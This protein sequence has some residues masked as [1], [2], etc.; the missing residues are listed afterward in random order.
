MLGT[1]LLVFGCHFSRHRPG[2]LTACRYLPFLRLT[3]L[4]PL[5]PLPL[6]LVALLRI[7]LLTLS[8]SSSLVILSNF[9]ARI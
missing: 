9:R 4:P 3:L 7:F 8:L 2:C 6:V 1:D 5:G